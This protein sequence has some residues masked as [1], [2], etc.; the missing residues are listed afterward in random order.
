MTPRQAVSTLA[1]TER[2]LVALDFDG[3]LSPLVD[4]PM[5]ARMLPA[6]RAALEA[7]TV[8]P[9]TTVALVSGR[10]LADLRVI[11][12]HRDDSPILLAGSHGA[13]HWVPGGEPGDGPSVAERAERDRL[14]AAAEDLIAG[15]P[16]AWIEP[17]EFG[18]AVHSRTVAAADRAAVNDR[19]DAL[20]VD[21]A[22]T[23]RRRTGHRIVE[24]AFRD[25][26]KDAAVAWLRARTG[27]TAVLF[28]GDDV[29]DEDA[30]ASLDAGDVGVRVGA[31]D[32][33]AS[34]RVDGIPELAAL[35]V[36]L[37]H[38]RSALQE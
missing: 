37:A 3:T 22:P 30:L 13:E 7:L 1:A 24:Y 9:A 28:A 10:S 20:M 33:A 16:G 6:A 31:G 35:L 36:L 19:V 4:A 15:I 5:D 29:T 8:T 18:F 26:G 12:E 27:A 38:E 34:V 32:T 14:R 25:V 2:L 23:W 11:A 21:E 17:K